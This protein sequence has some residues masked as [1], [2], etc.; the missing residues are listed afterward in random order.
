MQLYNKI[1][2]NLLKQD[3]QKSTCR[4]TTISFYRYYRIGNPSLFRDHLYLLLDDL[5]VLGRIYVASEGINAQISVPEEN[6]GKFRDRLDEVE[7]L[8]NIRLNI[9]FE[10]NGKSFFKLK[11]KVR[12]KILADGLQDETFDVTQVGKHLSA[13][14]FNELADREDT[15]IVD[16]RNHYESE[17][18]HFRNA[19][20]P[21]ADTFRE[22][23]RIAGEE[24]ASNRDKHIIMYCTGGIRCEKASAWFRHTGFAHIYQLEGGIIKYARD[25]VSSGLENKFIGKNFVFDERL[26]ERI[27]DHVI[28]KCHQCGDPCDSHTNCK[29]VAC[30]LLFIQCEG[31]ARKYEGCCSD[32]CREIH[33]LPEDVQRERRKKQDPGIRIYTKGRI[34]G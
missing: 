1:N 22:A 24:L 13:A 10:D 20:R 15:I 3:L 7:F 27:S 14:E 29:N 19:I 8:K 23:L 28:A 34:N 33:L 9:A 17:I 4:R 26:G 21:D 31:C 25:A 11:I 12:P 5:G 2:G 32:D 16:M 30:N 18:G 6:V